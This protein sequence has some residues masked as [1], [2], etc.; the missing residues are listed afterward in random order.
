LSLVADWNE[1]LQAC[2]EKM[3]LANMWENRLADLRGKLTEQYHT[4]EQCRLR[5]QGEL[6]DVDQLRESSFSNFMMNLFGRL[7]DK[8][9]EEEREAAEAKLKYDVASSALID[10]ELEQTELIAKLVDIGQPHRE[11]ER[12]LTEKEAWIREHDTSTTARLEDLSEEIARREAIRKEIREAVGAGAAVSAALTNAEDR[13]DSAGNWGKYDLIAGGLISTAIKHGHIDEA[14]GYIHEAQNSL[15]RFN[16]ELKDLKWNGVDET[17]RIGGFAKFADFFFDGFIADWI[18]QGKIRD[19]LGSVQSHRA[20]VE[21]LISKLKR[22]QLEQERLI[23]ES[24][25]E[26]LRIIEQLK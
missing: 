12:L 23:G 8:L 11:Y 17:A 13:L 4:V 5:L 16:N 3:Q 9:R 7:E 25:N 1:R 10:M 22:D 14:R 2:Q 18:V 15:R 26:F 6:Q 24:R 20:E 21:H 19:S